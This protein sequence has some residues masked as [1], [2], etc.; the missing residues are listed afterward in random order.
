MCGV[1]A[2][3]TCVCDVSMECLWY[4][5]VLYV[6]VMCVCGMYVSD[7]SSCQHVSNRTF[8]SHQSSVNGES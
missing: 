8:F 2:Y 4:V 1:Y 5:C 3:A 7:L 6:Y